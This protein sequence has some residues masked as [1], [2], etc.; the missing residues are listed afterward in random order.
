M[1]LAQRDQRALAILLLAVCGVGL[2]K[3]PRA[4]AP[5]PVETD[6]NLSEARL[7]KIQGLAADVE[8]VKAS[9]REAKSR[10]ASRESTLIEAAD[11][12]L[13][14]EKL[15]NI[16]E[17]LAESQSPPL[18]LRG[19]ELSSSRAFG[20]YGKVS[21]TIATSCRIEQLVNFI[22]DL[23]A[24][25]EA[26]ATEELHISG[27]SPESKQMRVRL[28]IGGLVPAKLIPKSKDLNEF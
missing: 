1:R 22:S 24:Q 25:P 18:A 19:K 8:P 3:A 11:D 6:P 16:V 27:V 5:S 20:D 10:L 15:L 2:S 9:F 14:Q 17:R 23:S 12:K 28:T 21:V 13:A 26:V 7:H 4:F